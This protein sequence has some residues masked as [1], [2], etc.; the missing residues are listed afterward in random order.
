M[1]ISSYGT[2]FTFGGVSCQVTTISVGGV[3]VGS[4][5]TTHLA[6]ASAFKEFV[7]GLGDG[8]ELSMTL[9]YAKATMVSL[10]SGA[11][12][13]AAF[14]LVL[15]DASTFVGNGFWTNLGIAI[16]EDD[17]V[18]QDVTIKITGKPVFTS[19]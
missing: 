11:R 17:R 13:V 10:Y 6:S 14:T 12:V 19:S 3:Q 16:P 1:A 5:E 7:A 2:T 8:G 15:P 18:T 9:N 4:I